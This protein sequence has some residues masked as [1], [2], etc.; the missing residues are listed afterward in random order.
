MAGDVTINNLS[1]RAHEAK[2]CTW[3]GFVVNGVLS[4]LKILAGIVGHS[5]AMIADGV[6]SISDFLTDIVVILFVD[7]TARGQNRFYR[8]GHGKFETLATMIISAALLAVAIMLFVTGGEKVIEAMHGAKI[9]APSKIALIMAVV[10]II[11]K[12]LLYRYTA[13]VGEHI[14]SMAVI[15]N[16]WHHRSD[17]FSSVATL[18]GIGG[19]MYLSEQWRIL[20]PIAAMAVSVFIGIVAFKLGIPATKELLEVSLPQS[21]NEEIG[22]EIYSVPEVMAYHNLRTRKNGNLYVMDFHI[23]VAPDLTITRAHDIATAVE[24]RLVEKYGDSIVNI[25]IEP[26]NGQAVNEQGKCQD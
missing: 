16:A 12:E 22:R 3:I 8:Y 17:A 21:V 6:H 24:H 25:H 14:H 9:D 5:G 20:D 19:A 10:S 7:V 4:I 15:A 11:S 23:K 18:L 2:K 13:H 26:Y 1:E